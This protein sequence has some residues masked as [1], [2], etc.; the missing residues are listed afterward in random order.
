MALSGDLLVSPES[1]DLRKAVRREGGNTFPAHVV[2][3]PLLYLDDRAQEIR[4][5][6]A[7]RDRV[8][9]VHGEEPDPLVLSPETGESLFPPAEVE[10]LPRFRAEKPRHLLGR[11]PC[12]PRKPEI[13]HDPGL[14]LGNRYEDLSPAVFDIA[15]HRNGDRPPDEPLPHQEGPHGLLRVGKVLFLDGRAAPQSGRRDDLRGGEPLRP[16]HFDLRDEGEGSEEEEE[17]H[18]SVRLASERGD[19]A[20]DRFLVQPPDRRADPLPGEPIPRAHLD[21][22]REFLVG[23]Q[24]RG[25]HLERDR[26]NDGTGGCRR[27]SFGRGGG[28]TEEEEERRRQEERE[29]LTPFHEGSPSSLDTGNGT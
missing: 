12:R 15:G 16:R 20:E 29:D 9:H 26:R 23:D 10:P 14:S 11:E 17:I 18:L 8:A 7:P 21:E 24:E 22:P 1:G 25:R 19:L 4:G 5:R 13:P 28:P 27:G 3:R 2:Q 6:L